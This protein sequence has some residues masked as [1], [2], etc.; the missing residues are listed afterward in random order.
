MT[1]CWLIIALSLPRIDV[2]T[3]TAN[4]HVETG[5]AYIEQGLPD[6]A[7]E[8]FTTALDISRYASEA[9]LGLA[10]I[11]TL[12]CSWETAEEQYNIYMDMRPDDYRA[13]LEMSAMLLAG[14]RRSYDALKYAE[15]AL[16]LVPL[17][18]Q[19]WLMLGEAESRLGNEQNAISWYTRTIIEDEELA[20]TARVKMG[21]LLFRR[22][23]L[24]EARD[25]LLPAA[26]AATPDA[27]HFLALLYMEQNDDLRAID[28]LNRYLFVQP[29]GSWSDSARVYLEDLSSSTSPNS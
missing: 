20:N 14:R 3:L 7:L 18:A 22:G 28:N 4:L 17:N 15:I 21:S 19:C 27:Y 11:A 10:R 2:E 6:K 13:P 5:M 23:D 1:T 29:N 26:E 9:H 12:N 24:A 16:E 8:E 25:I